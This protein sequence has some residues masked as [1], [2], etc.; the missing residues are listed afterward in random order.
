MK[1][2]TTTG[3][4]SQG[5]YFQ[6]IRHEGSG[7][8]DHRIIGVLQG[9]ISNNKGSLHNKGQGIQIQRW[10]CFKEIQVFCWDTHY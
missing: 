4:T 1:S 6:L 5:N 2:T 9:K 10:I 7:V 8:I 3:T